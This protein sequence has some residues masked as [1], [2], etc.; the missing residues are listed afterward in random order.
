[1]D[2]NQTQHS[3][4]AWW[5][6]SPLAGA[7][8]PYVEDLYEQYLQDPQSVDERWRRFFETLPTANGGGQD[9]P[10]AA[11]RDYFRALARQPVVRG[12]AAAAPVT[13]EE[14]VHKQV[15]VLQLLNA[16]RFGGHQL[17]NLDPLGLTPTPEV[18][19]LHL[20]YYG[21]SDHDLDTEFD[22][23]ALT[24]PRRAT[25]RN[26]LELM[27]TVYC[28]SI[29]AEYMHLTE[30]KEKRW[31]QSALEG[32]RGVPRYP[33]E[34]RR[35][36]LE[37]LTA[38]EG[39][40]RYLATKYVGA[41]RFGLEGGESLIPMLD[42]IVQRAGGMGTK[43]IIMG[44]A[45]RGRL[46]VLVN[47]L[48]KSP[49][50]L[51][52]EFEGKKD[53]KNGTGDVKYHMG[54]SSDVQT[55]GGGVHL[56]LAFNP[57]HLEIVG[58]VV[59]GSVR[60]R[61]MRRSDRNGVE[62]VPVIMHGDAAFAGQGVVMETLNMSQSR[63]FTTMGTV[64]IVINNQVGFTTSVQRDARSTLYCTDVAKMVNAPIFHV[65]G[66]DPEA[67]LFVTQLAL[68]YRM[69][70]RKDVVI[71]LFCYRRQ[72]HNESDDPTMTQPVM[73]KRIK[74]L[75][76]TR[77]LFAK[78]LEDDG[79]IAADHAAQLVKSYEKALEA[80][81]CVA[82][83]MLPPEK[84]QYQ[85]ATDWT[86]YVQ[87]GFDP[88]KAVET[89]VALDDIRE[90]GNKML[91]LPEGFEVNPQVGKVLDN[92]RKMIA[93]ALPLDWGCA[94][95]LA[96][97]SL[98]K[99]GYPVRLSGQDCGR[100]TFS[101][102]HAVLHQY[103]D[104]STYVSLRNLFDGQPDFRV[105]NSLLSEEAVLAFEYGYSTTDPKTMVIWEAQFGD[106]VNG[107]QVVV[108]QFMSAGEQK[109]GRL[110][111]LTLFLPHGYEGQGPEHS[112]ARLE[113][114]LQLC[115]QHN[116]FVCAPTSPAQFFHMIR[117]QMHLPARK[118]LV[119]MT[120]K[121][122]LRHRLSVSTL[123]DLS[124]GQ[125][126]LVIRDTDTPDTNKV[127]RVVLCSGKVYYD[128]YEKRRDLKRDDI[129]IIRVEQLYPFP[130]AEL[131]QELDRYPNAKRFIW[132]QEEPM[133]QGAWFPTQHHIWPLLPKGQKLEYAGR[134]MS[135]APAVGDPK[136]HAQQLQQFLEQALGG[137]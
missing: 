122:L 41:K 77:A 11:I 56:A 94:E 118:P 106:F 114:F 39:L 5:G 34:V 105:I 89:R 86:P 120:P 36:L 24:G 90:L 69:T 119:V 51:F 15:R 128:L 3:L 80:G 12:T 132:C 6:S 116:M 125:F 33:E 131:K 103:K 83:H 61:Q 101:H 44:M 76:T 4:N 123:E 57:S 92:R 46:N 133:N 129:A 82:P 27:K 20:R 37:R 75:P 111:G 81:A 48:G 16:Y 68:D 32:V 74:E 110:S 137:D 21:L 97:A 121:S 26:A 96:Y 72:G 54:F 100:G 95:L 31:I 23:G 52:K 43:E 73:Y 19:E 29:G 115:A 1:V 65:N 109:W 14:M 63:G 88:T 93:G 79:V 9:I 17:A 64:H 117:R 102:R 10:H 113:R 127:K 55:S 134:P 98:L 38:A 66:D 35:N 30:S 50:E 84:I 40:E 49:E 112:S 70:F 124:M 53:H 59:E 58:P 91:Q 60:A 13:D 104:G 85:Y 108:D 71:D 87:H 25:L 130:E 126:R 18:P 99:E 47:L 67:V 135:A 28:R 62:V 78:R 136:L 22:T 7:N 107:A 2:A 8:A 45:H 42:E